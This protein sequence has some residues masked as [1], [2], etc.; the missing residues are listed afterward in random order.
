MGGRLSTL[1]A[2][3][4]IARILTET[5][6]VALLGAS[7]NSARPSHEVNDMQGFLIGKES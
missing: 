5:R 6:T 4:D 1:T 7:H 3:A 2:D